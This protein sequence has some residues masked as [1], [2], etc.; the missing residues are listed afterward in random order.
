MNRITH[1]THIL[2]FMSAL[3]TVAAAQSWPPQS[4]VNQGPATPLSEYSGCATACSQNVDNTTIIAGGLCNCPFG[5]TSYLRVYD[6][7]NCGIPMG[8]DATASSVNFAIESAIDSTGT[9][10][11]PVNIRLYLYT[12]GTPFTFANFTLIHDEPISIANTTFSFV[13]VTFCPVRVPAGQQLVVELY[14]PPVNLPSPTCGDLVPGGN[15]AGS[16]IPWFLASS[17]GIPDPQPQPPGLTDLILDVALTE[18]VGSSFCV[19]MPN[20][21]GVPG[22]ITAAG[23]A[24]VAANQL[25]L[26]ASN[27]PANQTCVFL[28]SDGNQPLD[29][30]ALGLSDGIFCLGTS[31]VGA[32]GRFWNDIGSSSADGCFSIGVDLNAI[33]VGGPTNPPVYVIQPGDTWYFQAWYRDGASNNFTDAVGVM[34]VDC[35]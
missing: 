25:T 1:L 24:C 34:F 35:P 4:A 30:I 12:P 7:V 20:S 8:S 11:Q 2:L 26:V 27:L 33:P 18:A 21:T 32:I 22:S 13:C 28:A 10:S 5:D 14:N 15:L 29:L 3:S 31:T 19:N 17:C 23:S 6:P 9:G 16:T